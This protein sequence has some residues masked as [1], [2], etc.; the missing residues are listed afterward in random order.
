MFL[1]D[2]RK[3]VDKKLIA[4]KTGYFGQ[5]DPK[6]GV[7]LALLIVPGVHARLLNISSKGLFIEDEQFEIVGKI[8]IRKKGS[9]V[10]GFSFVLC[11]EPLFY[12]S[13]LTFKRLLSS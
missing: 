12:H 7:G 5:D 10:K 9:S 2:V 11:L 13:Y 3:A 1:N 8:T 6:A 4:L